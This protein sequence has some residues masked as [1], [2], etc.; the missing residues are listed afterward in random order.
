MKKQKSKPH[1]IILLAEDMLSKALKEVFND[2]KLTYSHKEF[3]YGHLRNFLTFERNELSSYELRTVGISTR[4]KF[5]IYVYCNGLVQLNAGDDRQPKFFEMKCRLYRIKGKWD[6]H[7]IQIDRLG[8]RYRYN[9]VESES[10]L[11]LQYDL[12]PT[13][14]RPI[15][16]KW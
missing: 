3:E 14:P 12:D 8:V 13:A 2:D 6:A 15:Q 7:F 11:A 9:A 10:G 16:S 1:P 5:G 4:R